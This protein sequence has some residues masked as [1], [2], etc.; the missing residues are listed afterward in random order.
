MAELPGVNAAVDHLCEDIVSVLQGLDHRIR[1]YQLFLADFKENCEPEHNLEGQTGD[2]LAATLHRVDCLQIK[3]EQMLPTLKIAAVKEHS[4]KVKAL[5]GTGGWLGQTTEFE[6]FAETCLTALSQRQDL[7]D[8]YREFVK[9][10][11][12]QAAA[13]IPLMPSGQDKAE[14]IR[15]LTQEVLRNRHYLEGDWRGESIGAEVIQ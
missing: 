5:V 8:E 14:Q 1:E 4:Q 2:F 9:A 12:D 13:E 6:R 7:L 10:A 11:R 15:A 3:I